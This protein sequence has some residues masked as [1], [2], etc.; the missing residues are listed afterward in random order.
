MALETHKKPRPMIAHNAILVRRLIF[1]L[2]RMKK[3]YT[4]SHEVG[5]HTR[6]MVVL[7]GILDTERDSTYY[8]MLK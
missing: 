5:N 2:C 1:K 6:Y 3:G 8:G 4:G 7:S